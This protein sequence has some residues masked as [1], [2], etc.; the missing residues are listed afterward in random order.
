MVDVGMG[1]DEPLQPVQA[2]GDGAQR[3]GD[4]AAVPSG[5]DGRPR[6]PCDAAM[7]QSTSVSPSSPRRR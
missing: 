7:P 3:G 1:D 2:P 5:P 4:T 6:W